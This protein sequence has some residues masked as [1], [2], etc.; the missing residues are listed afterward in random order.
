MSFLKDIKNCFSFLTRFPVGRKFETYEDLAPKIWLFP[1][2]GFVLGLISG[3]I[4]LILLNVLPFLLVGFI[5]LGLLLLMTGAHHT[6]GLLDFG[7]GLMVMGPPERKIEAM[8]DVA[9]GAGGFTLGFIILILTGLSISYSMNAI[10]L[11]LVLSEVGAKFGMV[12]ICSLGKSAGTKTAEPFIKL[13]K[14]K[15]LVFSLILSLVLIYL[16]IFILNFFNMVIYHLNFAKFLFGH[17]SFLSPIDLIQVSSIIIIFLI[18]TF[19]PLI[20]ILRLSNSNF[21]GLT[22]DCLGALNEIT[23]LF[24]LILVLILIVF[25]II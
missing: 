10:L 15:H 4:G 9:I 2:V 17:P 11:A 24:I 18:G 7:D 19:L 3:L 14:K 13:N 5:I 21:N 12:A 23:R 22:G 16:T 8:H 25:N 20:I 6:D 1:I